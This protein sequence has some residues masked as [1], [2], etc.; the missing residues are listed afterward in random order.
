MYKH[1]NRRSGPRY[2]KPGLV[3]ITGGPH[4]INA[5]HPQQFNDAL[6]AFLT[7]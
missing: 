4:G 1:G 6:L 7:R 3:V 2:A 5:S